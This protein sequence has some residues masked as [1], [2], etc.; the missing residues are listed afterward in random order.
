[1]VY[2]MLAMCCLVLLAPAVVLGQTTTA[3]TPEQLTKD[4]QDLQQKLATAIENVTKLAEQVRMNKETG[5]ANAAAIDRLTTLINDELH[6]QQVILDA[7][8]QKDSAGNDVLR[9]SAN[10]ERSEEFRD[11]MRKAVNQS[12]DT[13]GEFSIHNR[14]TTPQRLLVNR[15]EY[16]LN[17]DEILTL[18]VPVGTVT[19]RLPNQSLTNWTVGAP[20]Y[21][22]KIEIVPDT[23]TT[24]TAYRP[25]QADSIVPQYALLP[26]PA[27]P[28][29][30]QYVSPLPPPPI[31]VGPTVV[32]RVA[33]Y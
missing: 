3:R 22:Q 25:I 32:Y 5:E 21:S 24:T 26:L 20:T 30:A 27:P 28:A 13:Q 7:I 23:N 1:M 10:M 12:L 33:P 31:Y 8:T 9:L 6:K 19:A 2:R 11:D 17:P 18:K 15:T 14:M 4:V 29:A 16:T